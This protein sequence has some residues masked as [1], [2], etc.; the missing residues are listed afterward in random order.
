MIIDEAYRDLSSKLKVPGF[1]KGKVPRQVIDTQLGAENVRREAIRDGLPTLYM[2]GVI[3]SGIF[4]VSDPEIS[5]LQIEGDGS[6]VTFEAKVDVKPEVVVKDYKGIE[7]KK[8]DTEVRDAFRQAVAGFVSSNP[9]VIDPRKIL[10]PA[11]EAM[12]EV[13]ARKMRLFGC[14]GKA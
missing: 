11:R 5:A 2:M 1:R 6:S 8:P 12:R 10:M 13:V 9:D 7:I 3:D 4:P 14:A